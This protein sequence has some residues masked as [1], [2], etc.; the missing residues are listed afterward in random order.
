[1]FPTIE[2]EAPT[3]TTEITKNIICFL[4]FAFK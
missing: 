1:M 4:R 3:S 2:Q